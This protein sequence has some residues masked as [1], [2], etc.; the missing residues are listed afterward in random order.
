MIDDD[1]AMEIIWGDHPDYVIIEDEKITEQS[2]W[3]TFHTAV[4]KKSDG[5]FWRGVWETG[6]TEYQETDLN[7]TLTQVTLKE[8]LVVTYVPLKEV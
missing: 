6:S 3:S 8:V 7:F 1:A 5:T 4:F 2:R